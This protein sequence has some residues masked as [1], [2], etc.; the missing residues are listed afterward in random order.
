MLLHSRIGSRSVQSVA[1]SIAE[2]VAGGE[3]IAKS[4]SG[5]QRL[6]SR[7]SESFA[8]T[9]TKSMGDNRVR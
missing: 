2:R 8:V 6:T 1:E 7:I 9:D 3:S 5:T 4:V